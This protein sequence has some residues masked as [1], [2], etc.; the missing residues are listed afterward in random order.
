MSIPTAAYWLIYASAQCELVWT[1]FVGC[2]SVH[3]SVHASSAVKT[4][5][6]HHILLLSIPPLKS[7]M[8]RTVGKRKETNP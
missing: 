4:V 2:P 3:S 5:C 8:L 6:K 1:H 7:I